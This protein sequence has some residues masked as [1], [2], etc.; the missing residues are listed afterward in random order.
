MV[1]SITGHVP[2]RSF[3]GATCFCSSLLTS[4]SVDLLHVRD[5]GSG[6]GMSGL[7]ALLSTSS[8]PSLAMFGEAMAL[9]ARSGSVEL[10]AVGFFKR[11]EERRHKPTRN[12][13]P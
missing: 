11:F 13:I 1:Y 9:Q 12:L 6:S 10:Q 3:A 2:R 5:V 8:T 7:A 4:A